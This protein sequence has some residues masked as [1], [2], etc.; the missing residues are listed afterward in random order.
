VIEM[1]KNITFNTDD[2]IIDLARKKAAK[3]NTTLN[4]LFRQWIISYAKDS[5]LA[6]ELDIFLENTNYISAGRSFSRDELNER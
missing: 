3:S 6:D 5:N 1:L 2:R 4:V